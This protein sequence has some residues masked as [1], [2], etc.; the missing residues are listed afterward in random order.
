M[1]SI[2]VFIAGAIIPNMLGVVFPTTQGQGP[3]IAFCMG[4]AYLLGAISREI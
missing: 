4:M 3:A 1:K 2:L